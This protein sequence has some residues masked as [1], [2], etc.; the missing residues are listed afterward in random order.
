MKRL[1]VLFLSL[2]MLFSCTKKPTTDTLLKLDGKYYTL[3]DFFEDT[4]K[5]K[6][7]KFPDNVKKNRINEWAK[8]EMFFIEAEKVYEDDKDVNSKIQTNYKNRLITNY[9]NTTILD[10]IISEKYLRDLYEDYI[11]EVKAAHVLIKYSDK[12]GDEFPSKTEAHKMAK[13]VANKAKGGIPFYELAKKYS[14]DKSSL[15]DGDLGW[16]PMGKFTSNFEEKVFSMKPGDI[17]E[18]V[19]TRYGFHV[20]KLKDRRKKTSRSYDQLKNRVR[21]MAINK[22]RNKL[23]TAYRNMIENL[24]DEIGYKLNQRKTEELVKKYS[25]YQKVSNGKNN[26]LDNFFKDVDIEGVL[27]KTNDK[28]Y[29]LKWF[30]NMYK[31]DNNFRPSYL[32]QANNF[33]RYLQNDILS[34]YLLDKAKDLGL[35]EEDDFKNKMAKAR[36]KLYINQ[37]KKDNIYRD[38][39][40]DDKE[41]KKYYDKHKNK[42]F[43]NPVKYE[44]REIYS[45]DKALLDSIRLAINNGANFDT[46]SQKYTERRKRGEKNGYYGYIAENQYG[47]LGNIASKTEINTVSDSLIEIGSGYSL[48]KVYNKK[49][50]KPKS[51]DQVKGKIITT[52]KDRIKDRRREEYIS[53]LKNK[54]GFKIYWETVNLEKLGS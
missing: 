5:D 21:Q 28:E 39:D 36:R 26:S 20:I 40:V 33:N 4:S 16:T 50:G 12:E 46:L 34:E 1:L 14:D 47:P 3:L 30:Q 2:L 29:D 15:P 19:F 24:K 27:V 32:Q 41:I 54:Y 25:E 37:I 22:N 49:E 9:L 23:Q 8:N 6:F 10:S 35:H 11:S 13:E 52:I 48:I 44:V 18:P 53:K 31:T 17:S 38:I 42:K 7:I 43:M 51:L 45:K